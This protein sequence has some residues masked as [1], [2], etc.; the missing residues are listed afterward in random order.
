MRF[1]K[2]A[3]GQWIIGSALRCG[4]VWEARHL[5][6]FKVDTFGFGNSFEY[7]FLGLQSKSKEEEE[8]YFFLRFLFFLS[9]KNMKY[10]NKINFKQGL[11]F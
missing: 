7:L 6:G 4:G 3:L 2:G 5:H 10:K 8:E 1:E 9:Q 11:N